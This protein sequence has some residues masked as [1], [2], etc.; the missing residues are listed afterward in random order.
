M[1]P[2]NQIWPGTQDTSSEV[3]ELTRPVARPVRFKESSIPE[4]PN[5]RQQ[6]EPQRLHALFAEE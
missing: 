6:C 4:D 1:I 2:N 3:E 5:I